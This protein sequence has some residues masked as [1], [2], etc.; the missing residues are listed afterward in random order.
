[1]ISSSAEKQGNAFQSEVIFIYLFTHLLSV[2]G[3]DN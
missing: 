2:M 1:M 3:T